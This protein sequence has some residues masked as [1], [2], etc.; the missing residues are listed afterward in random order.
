MNRYIAFCRIAESG[1]FSKTAE[2]MGYS[3]SAISQMIQ[4]LE[5]EVRMELL[6]RSRGKVTLTDEGKELLPEVRTIV[7]DY[8]LLNE[9]TR[10]LQGLDSGEIRI[11]TIASVSHAW[12]P[13]MIRSFQ[14]KYPHVRF[15][16]AQ[17]DY[18]AIAQWI[19]TDDVDFGFVNGDA[20]SGFHKIPLAHDEMLAILPPS[21]PLCA[22]AEIPLEDLADEPY[23]RLE[24][25]DF[26]EPMNA[27]R[28]KELK[29]STRLKVYDDY[30]VMAMV[31]ENLGYSIIPEMNL[32]RHDYKI[33]KRR[34][35]PRI[36]RNLCAVFSDYH[37]LPKMSRRFIDFI[38]DHFPDLIRG[39]NSNES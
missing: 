30:T 23:I 16:L 33:E 28:A 5:N 19:D 10:E 21:H 17:G 8:H 32:R 4:S 2:E 38:E 29:P 7:N 26:N 25:G 1:S 14:K 35:K 36:T 24:E 15:S 3:Q 31:E 12:L 37:H 11:G 27:F 39:G 34:I 18:T 9:K 13:K 20:I 22:K 6:I